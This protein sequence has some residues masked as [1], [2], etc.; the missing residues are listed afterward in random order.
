[1]PITR[2][3]S[4]AIL[5]LTVIVAGVS[6]VRLTRPAKARAQNGCSASTIQGTFGYTFEGVVGGLATAGA[7]QITYDGSGNAT[8]GDTVSVNGVVVQRTYTTT[9]TVNS[10]CT[11]P[12]TFHDSLGNTFHESGVVMNGGNQIAE[13]VTDPGTV[14]AFTEIRQ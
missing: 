13:V 7:G 10:D 1:M 11:V 4:I 2:R 3:F 6:V 5:A 14:I 9:Y 8:G 12:T